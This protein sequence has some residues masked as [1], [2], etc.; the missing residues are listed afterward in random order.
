MSFSSQWFTAKAF[1]KYY[2][3][4]HNGKG[5][6]MHSPFVYAFI[7]EV[8]MDRRQY[9]AYTQ[10]E[11]LRQSLLLDA[12]LL[13][14]EDM[15]AGS[16]NGGHAKRTIQ[17]IAKYAAK[18]RKYGQLLFR[19]INH[20][21]YKNILELGTSLGITTSYLSTAAP[22][23][24]V[25]TLEGASEIALQAACNFKKLDLSNI[26]CVQGNFDRTLS[27][28][29]QSCSKFDFVFV[30]GNHRKEPTVRYF[31]EI[32]QHLSDRSVLIFDDIHWSEEMQEAWN[33]IK[34]D[35]RVMLSIDLFFI[36]IIFFDP[37]FK[38]PQHF[39]IRF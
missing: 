6:G 36:G 13:E 33:S 27:S 39:S 4:A 23:G 11:H 15:G 30:D 38:V 2:L 24:F 8:L 18:P 20:Y 3:T 12:T 32:I 25:T 5:H 28:V 17:S 9:Y 22:N 29:L 7:R 21:Q 34:E 26:H 35:P 10:V 19:I 14:V 1:L 31:N 16:I 37:A